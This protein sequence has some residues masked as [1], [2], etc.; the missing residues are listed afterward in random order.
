MRSNIKSFRDLI[1]WQKSSDLAILVYRYTEKFPRSEQSGLVNQMRRAVISISSN[2][3][4]GF[5]RNHKK[6]KIQFYAVSYGSVSELESQI[7][8]SKRLNYLND[9]QASELLNLATEISRMLNS[10]LISTNNNFSKSYILNSI[11]FLFFLYSIFYILNPSMALAARFVVEEPKNTDAV[12]YSAN[13]YFEPEGASVNALSGIVS[14]PSGAAPDVRTGD[15]VIPLWVESPKYDPVASKISFAGAIPNGYPGERGFIMRLVFTDNRA[16]TKLYLSG[17]AY[18]NDSKGTLL[19]LNPTKFERVANFVSPSI[20]DDREP[21]ESFT[22]FAEQNPVLFD[23]QAVVV[24]STTDKSSGLDHYEVA[25]ARP[26]FFGLLLPDESKLIWLKTDSPHVLADQSRQSVI[27]I[28]AV[29]LNG[30]E[31]VEKISPENRLYAYR[32]T[33]IWFILIIILLAVWRI[34]RRRRG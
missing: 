15:S 17:Q 30:N 34:A 22:P 3:A 19:K 6:E 18:L 5:K 10:L 9:E 24:F 2:I 7:E 23:G 33:V 29:D 13:I 8:I 4:E 28:K 25:E 26:G 1:V 14:L 27:Y 31:R 12:P 16:A 20:K 11:F 21:P 32:N